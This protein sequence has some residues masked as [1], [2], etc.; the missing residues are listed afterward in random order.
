MLTGASAL[1]AFQRALDTTG[2]NIA[3]VGTEGYSRQRV[4]LETRPGQDLGAG[5]LGNGVQV[6]GVARVHDRF[7]FDRMLESISA[8]SRLERFS[9]YAARL[10]G[11]LSN[12]DT[13]LAAP[14]Q[15]Y[16]DALQG[17]AADPTSGAAR[18]TV[19]GAARTLTA[20]FG[21]LQ[22]QLDATATDINARLAQA[23]REVT[24]HAS[25]IAQLNEQIAR[26]IAVSGGQPPND[27]LDAREQLLGALAQRI[28]ITTAT[29]DDG[30]VNVFA[31]GGQA[32]VIGASART[33]STLPDPY[34]PGRLELA[35]GTASG[36]VRISSQASGGA[37]G[38]LL[39]FRREV[40]DPANAELGRLAVSLALTVN[41][42]HAEGMDAY[43]ALGGDFFA[44][45][46]VT[47]TQSGNAGSG[48][49]AA[50]FGDLAQLTADDYRMTYDGA[51]WSAVNAA[52]GAAVPMSGTGAPGDPF[53]F[54]GLQV[55]TGGAPAAGDS[56]LL[57]PT[58]GAAGRITLAITDPS[59]IA[60]ASPVRSS[61]VLTNAGT[62]TI[63]APA[64]LDAGDPGLLVTASIVFTS[65][66]TYT[67]N[68]GP[69]Q[70]YASG[71]PISAN[72]WS[73]AI[74]GAPA[75][76]DSFTVRAN[77]AGSSDNA[78]AR[79]L[80]ALSTAAVLDGGT[81]SVSSAWGGLVARA[82]GAAQQA[83]LQQGAQ[84]AVHAQLRAEREAVSGVN[85]DEEAANL[86]RFQQAYQ[87]AAQVL[88]TAN[89]VFD[90]L[91][92]AIRR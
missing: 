72:G 44:A 10:D 39:D 18:S 63:G 86:L 79:L 69:P 56:F 15:N 85:L 41:A 33:M 42:Q 67:V 25:R 1:L 35:I 48:T 46:A 77:A 2:H 34:D 13:G 45:P 53:V 70:A 73:V 49:L 66:S 47:V 7:I 37:I 71:S 89:T 59:R 75:A 91:L 20:R 23:A 26:A 11:W 83:E 36:T 21:S 62:A 4:L 9:T 30:S 87:A 81:Q 76:G 19:L 31:A 82:G 28:G 84:Q 52:T 80:G 50:T 17:L 57:R 27:L 78:N 61:A 32:L 88:V 16:H 14:L 54:G 5:Y 29:Q 90:T 60:A 58:A 64:I 51:A 24:D 68:G 3:N 43:G 92:A 55:V 12:P 22:S 38:G 8:Q 6:A 74:S 65:A 40:L